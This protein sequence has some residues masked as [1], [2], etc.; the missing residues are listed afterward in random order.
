[1]QIIRD[2]Y[3]CLS[4]MGGAERLNMYVETSGDPNGQPVI[5]LHAA[6]VS[7]WMWT[8][9]VESLPEF[10]CIVPDLPGIDRSHGTPWESLD[11]TALRISALIREQQRKVHLVGMSLGAVVALRAMSIAPESIDRAVLSGPLTRP[12]TGGAAYLNK[13]LVKLYGNPTTVHLIA[14]LLQIPPED[15]AVFAVTARRTPKA[16]YPRLLKELYREPLPGNLDAIRI[17]TLVITGE[18]DLPLLRGGV[19][20]LVR[21]LPEAAGYLAPGVGHHWCVENPALFTDVVRAWLLGKP[22]PDVLIPWGAGTG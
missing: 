8:G 15:R 4:R 16:T 7:G 13:L 22:L 20:D 3:R 18:K 6:Q 2:R 5:F 19:D 1:M 10:H 14:R 11:D 12:V 9:I 21:T 17:P